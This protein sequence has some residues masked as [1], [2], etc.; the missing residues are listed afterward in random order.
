M[1]QLVQYCNLVEAAAA[2]GCSVDTIRRYIAAGQLKA[3]RLGSKAI[4]LRV[5]DVEA[6]TRSIP[7]GDAR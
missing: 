1:P 2:K 4:R 3:Y 6:L 7:T 5:D